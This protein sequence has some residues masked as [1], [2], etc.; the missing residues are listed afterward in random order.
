M[1]SDEFERQPFIQRREWV[2]SISAKRRAR[3]STREGVAIYVKLGQVSRLFAEARRDWSSERVVEEIEVLE[4][5][6]ARE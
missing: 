2:Y 1:V 3:D 6:Q 4:V 5:D